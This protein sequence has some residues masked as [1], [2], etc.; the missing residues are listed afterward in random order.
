LAEAGQGVGV[1]NR[2]SPHRRPRPAQRPARLPAAGQARDEC[3]SGRCRRGW[4]VRLTRP[5]GRL[6]A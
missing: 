4:P 5:A 6:S 3:D 2:R 1:R